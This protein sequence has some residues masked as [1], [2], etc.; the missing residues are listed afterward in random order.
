MSMHRSVFA[1][2]MDARQTGLTLIVS[3]SA[4]NMSSRIGYINFRN[5]N[6]I[7]STAARSYMAHCCSP[8]CRAQISQY[9]WISHLDARVA[10]LRPDRG[11]LCE[12]RP[13]IPANTPLDG[14][15]K[16]E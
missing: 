12:G 1:K 16:T 9:R 8:Y 14:N 13:A 15:E 11:A 2:L 4:F 5:F 6:G 10:D 3:M 7:S